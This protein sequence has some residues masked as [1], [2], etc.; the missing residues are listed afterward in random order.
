MITWVTLGG[1]RHVIETNARGDIIKKD[2]IP[3]N[4]KH[5]PF[6]EVRKEHETAQ[7]NYL[8]KHNTG[9]AQRNTR[10]L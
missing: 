3:V 2:G 5:K 7:K 10:R 1:K 6:E 4:T 8:T 9:F